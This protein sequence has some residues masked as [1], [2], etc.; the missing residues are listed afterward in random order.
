MLIGKDRSGDGNCYFAR[1]SFFSCVH[2]RMTCTLVTRL[3]GVKTPSPLSA[4]NVLCL[5]PVYHVLPA[6]DDFGHES[7]RKCA[8]TP[9]RA[10]RTRKKQKTARLAVAGRFSTLWENM[11]M[12]NI[13]SMS[14]PLHYTTNGGKSR[15]F[16]REQLQKYLKSRPKGA[17]GACGRL[18]RAQKRDCCTVLYSSPCMSPLRFTFP[19][20]ARPARLSGRGGGFPPH[21][22]S[23]PRAARTGRWR[24]LRPGGRADSAA[25][26][27]PAWHFPADVR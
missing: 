3:C 19:P 12:A 2:A 4:C 24:S 26:A 11:E 1:P 27:R 18:V 7:P 5:Y 13:Q 6:L 15:A 21:Q 9:R 17:K 20:A 14:L 8:E 10:G 22:R 25:P 23:R 16:L